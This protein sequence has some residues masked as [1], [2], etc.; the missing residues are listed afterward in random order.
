[1][2]LPLALV[3][4]MSVHFWR[5]RKDGG[6]RRAIGA[7]GGRDVSG[8]HTGAGEDLFDRGDCAGK[9]AGG[10]EGAGEYGAIQTASVLRRTECVPVDDLRLS[11]SGDVFRHAVEGI[12]QSERAGE[13]GQGTVALPGL[14]GA[15]S[16]KPSSFVSERV[17]PHKKIRQWEFVESI[18]KSP[19]G[20]I[21]RR[22]LRG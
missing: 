8:I 5:I 1:M 4:L 12:R 7:A 3:M 21:L 6:R 17:A 2:I 18:P 13:P 14:A 15:R 11:R 19:S 16:P 20:K 22:L 10:G 9:D